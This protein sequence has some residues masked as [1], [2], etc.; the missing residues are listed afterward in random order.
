MPLKCHSHLINC[1]SPFSFPH[2]YFPVRFYFI[3][4][5]E[6]R[7]NANEVWVRGHPQRNSNKKKEEIFRHLPLPFAQSYSNWRNLFFHTTNTHCILKSVTLLEFDLAQNDKQTQFS[8]PLTFNN[9]DPPH[10]ENLL[11]FHPFYHLPLWLLDLYQVL[12]VISKTLES[13]N[14]SRECK[15]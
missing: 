9:N 13:V 14:V 7:I 8:P 4:H 11:N 5:T 12:H 10:W 3:N 2:K 1:H 15:V 6:N